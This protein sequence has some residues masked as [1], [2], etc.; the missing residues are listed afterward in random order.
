MWAFLTLDWLRAS[1]EAIGFWAALLTTVA[2]GPQVIQAWR[3][4]GEGL[5]WIM[6]ALFGS[7]VGLWFLYGL[8]RMS[9]PLMTANGLTGI[10]VLF[11]LAIK[12]RHTVRTSGA[13]D[14]D[15]PSA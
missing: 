14:P 13:G 2:F 11:L 12:I 5:S 3:T 8:M 4:G 15:K 1:T 10:Q 9:G 7:G 6:L